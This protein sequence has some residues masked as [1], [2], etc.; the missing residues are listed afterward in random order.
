MDL[1]TM[2]ILPVK[3]NAVKHMYWYLV[4]YLTHDGFLRERL[5]NH[6][7]GCFMYARRCK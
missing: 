4:N 2:S 6:R 3:E 1:R 5:H 7:W